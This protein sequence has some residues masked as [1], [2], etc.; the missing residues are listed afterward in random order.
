MISGLGK[1]LDQINAHLL[2]RANAMSGDIE[3]EDL[4]L[5]GR[6]ASSAEA[7]ALPRQ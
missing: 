6:S 4:R 2:A 1:Q 7:S 3:T 5:V